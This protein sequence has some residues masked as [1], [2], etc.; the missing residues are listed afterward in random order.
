VCVCVCVCVDAF[1]VS[2]GTIAVNADSTVQI[3]AE[4]AVLLEHLD[5]SVARQRLDKFTNKLASGSEADR[6][7]SEIGVEVYSAMV[8]ALEA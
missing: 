5:A 6:V 4:E 3:I 8:K 1:I 2:S 7:E